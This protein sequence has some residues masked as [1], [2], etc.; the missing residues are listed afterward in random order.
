MTSF[1]HRF[2]FNFM[3]VV[4]GIL[5]LAGCDPKDGQKELAKGKE[6]FD[7]HNLAKAVKFFEKSLALAPDNVDALVYFAKAKLELGEL[8]AVDE[9]MTRANALAPGDLDVRILSAQLA[10]HLED[11]R[12]ARALYKA[13]AEDMKLEAAD[14]SR[15]WTGLG[16]VE[17]SENNPQL[18]RVDFLWAIRLDRRN[19]AAWYHLALLY[20]DSLGYREAALDQFEI[21]VRL[22]E[23]ASPRVQKVQRHVIPEL[24]EQ[25]A[26]VLAN[27]P[28]ASQRDSAASSSA[29]SKAEGAWKKKQYKTAL[30][31]YQ[32]ALA[33]DPLSY[34]AA[35]GLG[36]A[37]LMTDSTKAG[38]AKAFEK[39]KLACELRPSAISTFLTAGDMATKLGYYSQAVEIYSRAVAAA[40]TSISALDG[41]I[42]ALRR[43]GKR[44]SVAQA[45]QLYRESLKN[46]KKK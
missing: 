20:R 14:R 9:A 10:W 34:P 37:F 18:A 36:K 24:K 22:E 26:A 8:A 25:L 35:L 46:T 23:M 28:G 13:I 29:I 16:I 40:P 27:R 21:F 4:A 12:R 32:E 44:N 45:Y 5:I 1:S 42:G 15:G 3:A 41:F 39:Y 7:D 43:V 30:K 19:A 2:A 11:Y 17:M 33:A 6:A 31:F 38:R